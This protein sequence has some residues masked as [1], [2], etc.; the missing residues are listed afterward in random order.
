MAGRLRVRRPNRSA[1]LNPT[2]KI[3]PL[4]E[5]DSKD[6]LTDLSVFLPNRYG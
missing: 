4:A 5:V 3:N 1:R 6:Y 2:W